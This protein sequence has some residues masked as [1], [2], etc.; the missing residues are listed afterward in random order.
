M[1][2]TIKNLGSADKTWS[3]TVPNIGSGSIP[4]T[5][6]LWG[7]GGGGGGSDVSGSQS[8]VPSAQQGGNG[9]G[10]GFVT[11]SIN[12]S[13][14]DVLDVLVG[15][16]GNGG[17]TG[18]LNGPANGGVGGSSFED[19]VFSTLELVSSTVTRRTDSRW[20]A[21][22]NQYAVW[23]TPGIPASY[24][25]SKTVNFPRS[26]YWSFVVQCDDTVKIYIDGT[27]VISHGGFRETNGTPYSVLVQQGNRT[28]SWVASNAGGDVA[29]FAMN[30]EK[31]YSGGDGGNG[32][33]NAGG[34]GGGGGATIVWFNKQIAAVA[35]GGGGG[36]G[37]G[38]LATNLNGYKNG[39]IDSSPSGATQ[40]A[41]TAGSNGQDKTG[42]GGG[43][44]GGGGGSN[45][46]VIPP[47]IKGGGNG[48]IINSGDYNGVAGSW[49][50]ST[51]EAGRDNPIFGR[52][53]GGSTNPYWNGA[54]TGGLGSRV[55][56]R[57]GD[58][59]QNGFAVLDIPW[60]TFFIRDGTIWKQVYKT[61]VFS[62]G[63]KE[64]RPWIYTNFQYEPLYGVFD[65]DNTWISG[66]RGNRPRPFGFNG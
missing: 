48:G 40:L 9:G 8:I 53:P 59:G 65:V 36:G 20:G 41:L 38:E 18:I 45:N 46:I 7:G 64:A 25:G 22:M 57:N 43:G 42:T 35:G 13:T 52:T 12:V 16:G 47:S 4:I 19:R 14:G 6:Y 10:G 66:E 61:W 44:G 37:A 39:G 60:N 33:P 24:S 55:S 21:F 62:N 29:G 30:I 50:Y 63:W 31:S 27:E 56:W 32:A 58:Y 11:R 17:Q 28:L 2:S 5:L 51:P 34:G 49:G 1:P 23:P 54:G 26:D 3:W 15:R